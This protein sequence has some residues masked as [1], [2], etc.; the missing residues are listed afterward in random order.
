VAEDGRAP[1]ADVVDVLVVIH[2]PD[3]GALGALHKEGLPADAAEGADRGID[4]ARDEGLGEAEAE[5]GLGVVH[6]EE[7]M[8]RS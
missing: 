2:I 7:G 8:E 1:G 6:G 3:A 4:A 5:A